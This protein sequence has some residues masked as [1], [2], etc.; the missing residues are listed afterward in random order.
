[1]KKFSR[2]TFDPSMMGGQACIRGMRISVSAVLNMLA[3]HHT[4]E[5]IILQY[6]NLVKEDI[7]DCIDYNV[8]L[9]AR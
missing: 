9:P 5:E 1:M 8:S 2:I 4:Q 3:N 7:Q 6:P